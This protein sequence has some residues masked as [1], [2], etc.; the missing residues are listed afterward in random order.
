MFSEDCFLC[1]AKLLNSSFKEDSDQRRF[2]YCTGDSLD[3][4]LTENE[5]WF[6]EKQGT[7]HHMI[8]YFFSIS[9]KLDL[10]LVFIKLPIDNLILKFFKESLIDKPFVAHNYIIDIKNN[11][12]IL[13]KH[14][15]DSFDYL[16][17][18]DK[19]KLII[20]FQ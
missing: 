9:G 18:V 16:F 11:D 12:R 8:G 13:S 19:L 17:D 2:L 10:D 14:C 7:F 4:G 5:L 20:S 6:R 1:G 15:L 3:V